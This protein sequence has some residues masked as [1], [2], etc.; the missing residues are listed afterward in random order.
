MMLSI[1]DWNALWLSCKLGTISTA[2]LLIIAIPLGMWL[3]FTPLRY[4]A[5]ISSILTL[6]LILP[7]TVLGFYLLL[8]MGPR[9]FIGHLCSVFGVKQLTFTFTGLVIA[10]IIYSLPF[11]LLPIQNTFSA[12]GKSS[13]EVAATLGAKPL[14]GIIHI[15]LPQAKFAIIS[16]G[17]IGFAHTIGEFGVVLM[18]G[19]NIPQQTQVASIQIYNHFEAYEYSQVNHLALVLLGF[20]FTILLFIYILNH[21]SK[22]ATFKVNALSKI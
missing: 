6:P 2:I 13:L 8:W 9:G 18:L 17:I 10:S 5:I 12:I 1:A 14:D 7:P 16:A 22:F 21:K 15:L 4:K 20:S 3:A 19:G 11:V